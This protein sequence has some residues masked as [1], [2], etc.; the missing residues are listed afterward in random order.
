[1]T[2]MIG[3]LHPLLVHLPIGILL[4]AA[5]FELLAYFKPFRKLKTSVR[6][7]ILFGALASTLSVVTGLSLAAGGGYDE[8]L[9]GV[10]KNAGIITT[11]FAWIIFFARDSIITL[12]KQKK[13]RRLVR[14]FLFIPLAVLVGL[15]GHM[16]GSLT[17]GEDYLSGSSQAAE[18]KALR[19]SLQGDPDSAR[20][21]ADI[22]APILD[23]RCYSCHGP[24]KQK[25]QLRLDQPRFIASGGKHGEVVDA[26]QPDSSELYRRL[27]L[28]LE[29]D[30]HMPPNEKSQLASAE[31]ALIHS[32]L[33][34]GAPFDKRISELHTASSFK[35]Y[36]QVLVAPSQQQRILPAQDVEPAIES[37]VAALTS[38]GVVVIPLGDST[39]YL[40]V[41]YVNARTVT[42]DQLAL[43]LPIKDQLLSLDLGRTAVGNG[44][45]PY[46]AKLP[47]L[48]QLNL[49][50]TQIA[51]AGL[52]GI[53]ALSRLQLINLVGTNMTDAGL[54]ELIPLKSLR[55][56]YC[57]G[58]RVTKSGVARLLALR[59]EI[60]IDTGGYHLPV[61]VTDTLEYKAAKKE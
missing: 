15:T 10:H 58:T 49:Q 2:E 8:R 18:Q 59:P 45:M 56:V 4:L 40:S 36:L 11:I 41:S 14:V 7:M 22:I 25:G 39:H 61:R 29:D 5:A 32:W 38:Q 13:K 1:M 43:L 54:Q 42:D 46:L 47:A 55:K 57:Y 17:H 44:A 23:T 60:A 19:L 24:T 52:T 16:G 30:H 37:A 50:H 12:F 34:E 51:D 20:V 35:R 26:L 33:A 48:T 31:L 21:Y 3:R 28:P 27:V 6:T 9:I 53:H